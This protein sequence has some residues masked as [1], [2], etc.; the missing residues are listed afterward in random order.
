MSNHYCSNTPIALS[1]PEVVNDDSVTLYV[2][3]VQI[4]DVHWTVKHRYKEFR[5]LHETLI[6]AG[7]NKESLPEKKYVGNKDPA[8]IKKRRKDLE[9]YLQSIFQFLQRSLPQSLAEFLNLHLYDINFLL[10]T[11]AS[12]HFAKLAEDQEDSEAEWTPLEMFAISER[13]KTP[14]P[15]QDPTSLKDDFT[16]VAD[17]ACQLKT[18]SLKG[19]ED[20][21]GSSNIV[22]NHLKYDYFAFKSLTKLVLCEVVCNPS[23]IDGLG[24][25]RDTLTFLQANKCHLK[26]IAQILLCDTNLGIDTVSR[27]S[28]YLWSKLEH[29]DLRYN[30]IEEIDKAILLAPKTVNLLLGSNQVTHVENL[31][32]LSQ[33]NFL[34]LADNNVS[35]LEDLNIK[36][37][38]ISRIDVSHNKLKSLNGFR[39]LYSLRQLNA[40]A[41]RIKELDQ[42]FPVNSLPCLDTLNLQSN[43]VTSVVD[44]R[45]KV[46]ESFGKR[47]SELCLD[48]ECPSQREIDK[49][50]VL[51]ALRVAREG[52]PPTSLFGNLPRSVS[53][54]F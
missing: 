39:K 7:V 27:D 25:V 1:I 6:E 28:Q 4:G 52:Q 31:T 22:P 32:G 50:S 5:E 51:M 38:Q 20:Q 24:Q 40:S 19:N 49:V 3:K 21:L 43:P 14:L 35:N 36:L 2:I 46:L 10:K 9:S 47:C 44:Y 37:G 16:N 23:V 53:G 45:L 12:E 48:N 42:I 30:A 33:L 54:N 41:N 15:P 13:L 18:L 11:L 34:E 29:L 17:K 8:F 26:S